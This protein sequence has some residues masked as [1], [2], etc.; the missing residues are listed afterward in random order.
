MTGNGDA[1]TESE[2][3]DALVGYLIRVDIQLARTGL[4][5]A[6][7]DSICHQIIEQFYDL[8][9][10][11]LGQAPAAQAEATLAKLS[12][13]A[14]F[15]SDGVTSPRQTLRMFWHRFW[16]GTPIPL[17]LN[18]HGRRHI[19]LGELVRRLGWAYLIAVLTSLITSMLLIGT[20]TAGRVVFIAGFTF[21]LPLMLAVT[22]LRAP[23]ASLPLAEHWPTDRLERH[24]YAGVLIII[25]AFLLVTALFPLAYAVVA[26]LAQRPVWPVERPL[27]L[28]VILMLAGLGLLLSFGTAWKKRQRRLLFRRWLAGSAE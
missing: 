8:L 18:D 3:T 22:I 13:D 12:S 7:R 25:G 21:G 15:A 19:L 17:A 16:I 20:W 1:S 24:R 14:A 10:A 5:R 23:V 2:P 9:P 11:E 6:E 26:F 27:F 28:A 4:D